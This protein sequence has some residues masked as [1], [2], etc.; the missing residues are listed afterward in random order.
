MGGEEEG[1]VKGIRGV[2]CEQEFCFPVDE[3]TFFF[4]KGFEGGPKRCKDCR[5]EKKQRNNE[6][7]DGGKGKG[8][9]GRG[10]GKGKGKDSKGKGKGGCGGMCFKFQ[11]GKCTFG[12]SCRFSHGG[13]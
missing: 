7:G 8:K 2:D 13:S 3:Q 4:E 10:K 1:K 9:D 6:G 11:E 12:D 5:W